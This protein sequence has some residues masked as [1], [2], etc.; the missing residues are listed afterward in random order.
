M[1]DFAEKFKA[2]SNSEL[3]KIIDSPGDYQPLAVETARIIY[4]SRNLSAQDIEIAKSELAALKQIQDEKGQKKKDIENKVKNIAV[5]SLSAVNQFQTEKP[6]S[7]KIIK[8]ISIVFGGLGLFQLYKGFEIISFMF[9]DSGAKW[10]WSVVL[11]FL[12]LLVVLTAI[13]LFYKRKKSGW[14]LLAIFLT[15]SAVSTAGLL[16]LT[17]DM[18]SSGFSPIYN[19]FPKASLTTHILTLLFY[20]GT[21][22]TICK[23]EIREIY[24]INK[25]YMFLTIGIIAT[26]TARIINGIVM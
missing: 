26:L 25:K 6:G 5:K 24:T 13:I 16:I 2:Y 9:T 22:W 19:I 17:L 15:Y 20:A 3:L 23:E 10:D 14:T 1:T 12:S 11:Y 8:I 7:D 4:A 18:Q 21:L